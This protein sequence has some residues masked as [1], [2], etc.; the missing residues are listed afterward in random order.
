MRRFA[1]SASIVGAALV[2]TWVGL[3]A[4]GIASAA[5]GQGGAGTTA[6]ALP[7]RVKSHLRR[8]PGK[9]TAPIAISYVFS[10][11]PALEQ[12]FDVRITASAEGITDLDLTVRGDDGLE[13]GVPVLTSSSTDGAERTW[14]VS[15]TAGKEG[16]R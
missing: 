2:M 14:T 7:A 5:E 8:S 15:A 16:T 1:V 4:S 3:G 6:Q 9:P 13:V 10:A 12:P 11:Q